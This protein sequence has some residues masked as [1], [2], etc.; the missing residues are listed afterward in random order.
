MRRSSTLVALLALGALHC[1]GS[2]RPGDEI[3][4]K[5]STGGSSSAGG[6]PEAPTGGPLA[7]NGCKANG[8]EDRSADDAD[9]TVLIA[10]EGIVY[11]PRC[12]RI[13]RGQTVHWEGRLSAHPMSPGNADD[14]AAGSPR[15]PIVP[16]STGSSVDFTFENAGTF[17]YHCEVHSSGAGTG[18]AG[19]IHAVEL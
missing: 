10:A 18:M 8:Y 5:E 16:T 4:S 11:T 3:P 12:M 1:S 13:A 9:R 6:A 2:E 7:I 19:A 15:N 14:E 17:P